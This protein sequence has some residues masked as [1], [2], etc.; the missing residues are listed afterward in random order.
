[1]ILNTASQEEIFAGEVTDVY[2]KRTKEILTRKNLDKQVR[3]ECRAKSIPGSQWGVYAGLDE[4][5]E[6][7][8]ETDLDVWSMH[9]GNIFQPYEPVLTLEGS[10]RDFAVL[11]TP[12][13]GF[14]C[15]ATG[16]ASKAARVKQAAGD[17]PVYHFGARRMHPAIAPMIGRSAYIGGCD[18]VAVTKTAEMLGIDPVGTIPHAL[19]LLLEDSPTATNMFQEIFGK[20]VTCV[21]LV[22]T[23]GDEKFEALENADL[24]EQLE[25]IRLDTPSSRR[26]DMYEIAKEVRWELDLRGFEH[27][28]LFISGGLDE[29]EIRRLNPVADA[30]GVGT[31][32][33]NARVVDFALDIV[34]IEGEPVAKRGKRSGSKNVFS[35]SGCGSRYVLPWNTRCKK[36]P[37]CDEELESELQKVLE[38]GALNTDVLKPSR[39]REN[40][41]KKVKN[42]NQN[43]LD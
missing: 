10:Y 27:I 12:L 31:S 14:L 2:F 1:M 29:E 32:I 6:L 23:F 42:F 7:L 34:E 30:Y 11:E 13:L 21:A 37:Q 43:V 39:I 15:Q 26:G 19:V 3:M 24:I 17:L 25:A 5:L 41:L 8:K 33:S 28:Q 40:T 22:D 4:A 18:G 16:I 35:C 38:K 9:E 20:D 36:C